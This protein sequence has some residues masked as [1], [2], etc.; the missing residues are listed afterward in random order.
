MDCPSNGTVHDALFNRSM[1]DGTLS[2]HVRVDASGDL[3]T[4]MEDDEEQWNISGEVGTLFFETID[5]DGNRTSSKRSSKPPAVSS[6][7]M[8]RTDWMW[9]S[10]AS[11]S[12]SGG[13]RVSAR[14][15]TSSCSVMA[16]SASTAKAKQNRM[17]G[18]TALS[19]PSNPRCDKD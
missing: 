2:E 3:V 16:H 15:S 14:N 11:E 12:S 6:L 13:R 19:M 17:S 5:Q 9:T 7:A 18:S 1:V 10:I 8:L 4:S